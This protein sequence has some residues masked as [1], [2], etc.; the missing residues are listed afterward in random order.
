MRLFFA[1]TVLLAGSSPVLAHR[2]NIT[3]K[4]EGERVRV[5]AYYSDDTPAQ[6]ARVAI[7]SGEEIVV[8]GRTDEQ[9][10]WWCARPK[11]G[12]YTVTVES[13]GHAAKESLV[14][15]DAATVPDTEQTDQ[16]K[17]RTQT[18]WGRLAAGL[19]TIGGMYVAWLIV[20]RSLGRAH[21]TL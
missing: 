10:V 2:L 4:I 19:A 17:Q 5:E 12:T 16:R 13:I 18:P 9:G 7:R 8:E 1:V 3:A 11:A 21:R 15:T 6:E 20:R 14:V